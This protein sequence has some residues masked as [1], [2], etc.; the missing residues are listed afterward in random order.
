MA[1]IEI[2]YKGNIIKSVNADETFK[3]KSKGKI[4]SDDVAISADNSV[5][6][7]SVSY[8]GNQIISASG[9][10]QYKL[11]TKN[12]VMKDDVLVACEIVPPVP[13]YITFYSASPFTIKLSSTSK[14]WNG[15]I[16]YSTNL[17]SWSTWT[18]T[19]TL[20]SANNGSGNVLYMR[21]TGNTAITTTVKY[22]VIT[23]TA[24]SCTGN[25][26]NLLDYE[27]VL[28]GEHPQ[29]R[30][31]CYSGM[32]NGCTALVSAPELP[33]TTL[34]EGC[35]KQMFS[36][37]TSLASAPALPATTLAASC[38]DEM[39]SGCTSLASAPVLPA[40]TMEQ[41]CY[42][43]M[44]NG[45]TALVSAPEL[46]AT[47]L[48]NACYINM[49]NGCTALVSA[50]VLPATTLADN[51]YNSMFM[52]CTALVSAPELPVI[53]AKTRCYYSMFSGCTSLASAPALPATTLAQYCY[54]S[55]FKD[56]TALTSIP[57]LPATALVDYCY[58][59][60]F[61]GCTLIALSETQTDQYRNGYRVP[62]SGEGT[63][64]QYSYALQNMFKNT[65][66]TFVGDPVINTTYYTSNTIIS[67]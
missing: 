13:T 41:Y 66:G 37:C 28:N 25:I 50:P 5:A 15:T 23:G 8:D 58:Q 40:T 26:E 17:S 63:V 2:S 30:S 11:K 46:P 16:Q 35:Y 34:M 9:T 55:M 21:G 20:S 10:H 27:T 44:F 57:A 29:M 39:F 45:C 42:Q 51:C 12:K 18:G 3:L 62:T 64:S 59:N 7:I 14:Q 47:T 52:G 6:A 48:S 36:G 33:A 1:N 65:G 22:F 60:M 38:Y 31:F 43:K 32:F 49:F 54:N 56:C 67:A 19:G 4:M 24:V 53:T 61:N